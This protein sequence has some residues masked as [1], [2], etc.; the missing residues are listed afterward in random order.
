MYRRGGFDSGR[1]RG[2]EIKKVDKM[3]EAVNFQG[4]TYIEKTRTAEKLF[5]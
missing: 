5:V 3:P 1:E 2:E 4:D